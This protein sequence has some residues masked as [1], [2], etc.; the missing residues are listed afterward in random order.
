MTSTGPW[1]WSV[2]GPG[3]T[4]A[5]NILGWAYRHVSPSILFQRG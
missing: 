4:P 1:P 5:G 3:W 2:S